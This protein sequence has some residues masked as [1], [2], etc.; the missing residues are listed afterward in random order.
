[1][2]GSTL[3]CLK[4]KALS[5]YLPN[6]AIFFPMPDLCFMRQKPNIAGI[7]YEECLVS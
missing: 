1:M 2:G 4:Y 3:K 7:E 6:L 5:T